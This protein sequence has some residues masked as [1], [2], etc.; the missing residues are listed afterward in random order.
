MSMNVWRW[1]S[2][3]RSSRDSLVTTSR[4]TLAL[5]SL[6]LLAAKRLSKSCR[7][8]QFRLRMKW[9][10]FL[11]KIWQAT[12]KNKKY[13]LNV[14]F[15]KDVQIL[16]YK[17]YT[18]AWREWYIVIITRW[19]NSYRSSNILTL[20]VERSSWTCRHLLQSRTVRASTSGPQ[21]SCVY[22]ER[23]ENTHHFSSL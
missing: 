9:N 13:F 7:K 15:Q 1:P 2:F 23:D 3:D 18:E 6:T 19:S 17:A 4:S 14:K 21:W 12:Y 11:F 8:R 16:P 5:C 22:V 10:D 20:S